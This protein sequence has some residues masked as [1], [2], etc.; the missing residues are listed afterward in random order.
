MPCEARFGAGVFGSRQADSVGLIELDMHIKKQP[1]EHL[2]NVGMHLLNLHAQSAPSSLQSDVMPWT[3]ERYQQ[4]QDY[5]EKNL[6]DFFDIQL[7]SY[8]WLGSNKEKFEMIF[9]TGSSWVWVQNAKC[10]YC[11][12]NDH[13][14]HSERSTTYSQISESI[15][16]LQYGKGTVYGYNSLDD[17]CIKPDG[18]YG[19]GCMPQYLFKSVVGQR[20]L[21]GLAGA[22]IIGLSPSTHDHEAQLFVPT[23][24]HSSAIKKNMFAMFIDPNGQ[25]KIQMGGYDLNK[26]ARGP[27][28]WHDLSSPSFWQVR[29]DKVR[30]GSWSF[31]PS[32]HE[33]MA[34]SGTSL[35]MIPDEDFN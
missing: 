14:F 17:V 1:R 18:D 8:I 34:D 22:G 13:K 21:Q 31:K 11:M 19:D 16:V 26:Y 3:M 24:Y 12:A 20:D 5:I 2:N 9:D 10:K 28:H 27:I 23:L 15:S 32:T 25:S 6:H 30:V 35:N 33:A 4:E 7:Y 29:F